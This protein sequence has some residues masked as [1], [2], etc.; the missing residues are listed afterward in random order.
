M[1]QNI[2]KGG[3]AMPMSH[4]EERELRR[5]RREAAKRKREAEQKKL[6][7]T[8]IIAAVLLALFGYRF[9]G[10]VQELKAATMKPDTGEAQVEV[11]EAPTE[12]V[13]ALK[14]LQTPTTIHIKAAGDLNITNSVVSAGLSATGYDYSRACMDVATVLSDADGT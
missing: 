11:T 6:R 8:L 10:I 12:T 9:Y 1:K 7:N 4:E 13:S 2:R 14:A 3:T 5:Q